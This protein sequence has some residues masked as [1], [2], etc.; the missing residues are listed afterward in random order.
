MDHFFLENLEIYSIISMRG[1]P[2]SKV[3]ALCTRVIYHEENTKF[4]RRRKWHEV[5][6][7][8][9]FLLNL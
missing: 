2:R 8:Y 1:K 9:F 4:L 7:S 5:S 6:I 3:I